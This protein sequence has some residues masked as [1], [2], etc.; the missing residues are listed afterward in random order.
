MNKKKQKNFFLAG[1]GAV[2]A[3]ARINRS[4]LVLF[5]KKE[6]PVCS[7]LDFNQMLNDKPCMKTIPDIF[8]HDTKT[9]RKRAFVPLDPAHVRIYLCGTTVYD[10]AHIGNAR[11]VV[12]F[13]VLVR[14]LRMVFPRVTY[15]RNITDIDDKINARSVATG[16]PISTITARTA[17]AY[18]ADMAALY[19]LPPDV[20]PRATEHI[21]E[22]I[23]I[24]E[25]LIG[26]GHA[27]EAA[28]HVLFAVNSDPDYGKFSG[29]SPEDLLAGARV[30]VAP[31]KREPGDFVLWKPSS[32]ELPGWQSPWG[33]GRPGWHIECSAM[34]RKHLGENFDIH[35]GGD[36]LI[37]PHHE[38]EIAQSCCA[39]PGSIF[40]NF[41]LHN[42]MVQ[43]NGEK[44]SKSL[45]NFLTV[46]DGLAKAP[47]EAI[48][49]LLLR[50]HYRSTLDFSE[51]GLQECKRELD[52]F[53]RALAPFPGLK[54]AETVSDL[55]L[56]ALCDDLNT[57]SAI[58]GLH[59]LANS[60]IQGVE[61]S[62]RELLASGRLLG[63]FN[64]TPEEWFRSDGDAKKI[65]GL[66][67]ERR[68]AR[69]EKNFARA[70]EI[71][72]VLEANGIVLEDTPNGTTWRKT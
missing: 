68:L 6:L 53:Y 40:S 47:G 20:E 49:L 43:L 1:V 4:F 19:A 16:E 27:Y 26:N 15:V 38:N 10:L 5:F 66:I 32:P 55:V 14:L 11:N 22:I 35:G 41:W 57:P 33:R 65:D 12:V 8:L 13:D 63:L 2:V 30:D 46:R 44:M 52:R 42:R 61:K 29:R 28:G 58:A 9:R 64:V 69:V 31:Y 67:E 62:A 56:D 18:E 24:A 17:A 37:F 70:D 3:K 21:P 34:A 50:A 59:Q 39:F 48:R 36:D 51:A 71:R 72:K 23:D 54:P 25:R 45:G 7:R 60:A